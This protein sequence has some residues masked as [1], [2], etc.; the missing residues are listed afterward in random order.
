MF[1]T[2]FLIHMSDIRI[3]VIG[4]VCLASQLAILRGK[5]LNIRHEPQTFDPNCFHSC[6][7]YTHCWLLTFY[8]TFSDLDLG[9]GSQGQF[10]A[11]PFWLHFLKTL[12]NWSGWRNSSRTFWYY[13][14]VRFSETREVTAILW[15]LSKLLVCWS[16]CW[17][18]FAQGIFRRENSVYEIF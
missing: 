17:I 4:C 13:F 3:Y 1:F 15:T 18:G 10:R 8:T 14:W 12:L 2:F 5:N 11:K 9:W 6:S 16:L 7:V